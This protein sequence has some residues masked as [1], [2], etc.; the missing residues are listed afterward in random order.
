MPY[1]SLQQLTNRY[2]ERML[3]R[4][5]DRDEVAS[6]VVDTD[7]IDRALADT[8][9]MIDGFLAARYALPLAETPALVAE[10][11]QAI[12]IYKLHIYTPDEKITADYKDAR[13]ALAKLSQGVIRL[14]LAGREPE[15]SGGSGAQ[16]SD[17]ERPFDE[18]T[19]K[20]F[21]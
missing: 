18:R 14:D 3:I 2:G 7:V 16:I 17:R 1:T 19:M 10:L 13:D 5:T 21:I 6:G 8:D 15:T 4:L 9:A 11:A 12:A 20:G